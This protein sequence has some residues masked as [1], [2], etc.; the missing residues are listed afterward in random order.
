MSEEKLIEISIHILEEV[1][2]VC[3]HAIIIADRSILVDDTPKNLIE[4][5]DG[6]PGPSLT[7]KSSRT[8]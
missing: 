2:A 7:H 6:N 3:T 4:Q 1:N 5:G 8:R